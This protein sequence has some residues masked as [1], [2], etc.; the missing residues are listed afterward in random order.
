MCEDYGAI[1]AAVYAVGGW[2]DGYTSAILRLLDGLSSARAR[3]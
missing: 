3:G 1:E 2:N